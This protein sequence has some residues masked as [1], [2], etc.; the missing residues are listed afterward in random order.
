MITRLSTG[1]LIAWTA[2]RFTPPRTA[3]EAGAL[4]R[5]MNERARQDRQRKSAEHAQRRADIAEMARTVSHAG[6]RARID[7]GKVYRT[8]NT[9]AAER[10]TEHHGAQEEREPNTVTAAHPPARART[11]AQL[12][13]QVYGPPAA[14]TDALISISGRGAR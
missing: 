2:A 10:A 5:T 7:V 11:L 3:R 8:R 1:A 12:A 14:G 9:P 13:A 4:A 6:A